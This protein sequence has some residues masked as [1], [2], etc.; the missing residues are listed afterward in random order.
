MAENLQGFFAIGALPFDVKQNQLDDGSGLFNT[1]LKHEASWHKSCKDRINSTKL[2]RAEKRK[3]QEELPPHSPRKTRRT[4]SFD[5]S[6]CENKDEELCFFC[7]QVPGTFGLQRASTFELDRKVRESAM[8]LQRNDLLAKLSSGD[9]IA[10]EAKY[11][12]RCLV[13][14]YNDVR[15]L[16]IKSKSEEEKSMS[17]LHGIAFASLVSYLEEH[18]DSGETAPVFKLADLGSLYSEKLQDS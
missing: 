4:S 2:K 5:P 18:R 3:N 10:S 16:E 7:N 14:L 13:A 12:A 17:S 15:K 11:H 1:L 9:M 8:K 6:E